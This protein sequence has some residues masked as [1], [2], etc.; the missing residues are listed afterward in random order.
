MNIAVLQDRTNS[1][2][3]RIFGPLKDWLA[4]ANITRARLEAKIT[5]YFGKY[6]Y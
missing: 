3:Y 5:K 4:M 2:V 1:E 6:Y